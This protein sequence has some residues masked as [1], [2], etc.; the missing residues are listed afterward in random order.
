MVEIH[1][2]VQNHEPRHILSIPLQD[3]RRLSLRPLKWLHFAAFTVLGAKG[4]L[5]ETAGGDTV[6]YENVTVGDLAEDK[7]YYF[8]PEGKV[9][10]PDY[11]LLLMCMNRGVESY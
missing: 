3:I 6:D 11:M 4:N 1:L 7:K 9:H 10:I 5:S 2:C 8:T